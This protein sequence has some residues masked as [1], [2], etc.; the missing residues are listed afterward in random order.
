MLP[1]L[2]ELPPTLLPAAAYCAEDVEVFRWPA[3]LT[4]RPCVKV[5]LQQQVDTLQVHQHQNKIL[6]G[7][8]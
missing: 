4:S 3:W 8:I 6:T 2:T 1:A 7:S 5:F